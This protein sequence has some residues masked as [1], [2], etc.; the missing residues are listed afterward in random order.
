MHPRIAD[1]AKMQGQA[2]QLLRTAVEGLSDDQLRRK[3]SPS[4]NDMLWVAAHLTTVRYIMAGLLGLGLEKP[5][6]TRFDRGVE[7]DGPE[8]AI[9]EILARLDEVSAALAARYEQLG[10]GEL[11]APSGRFP[12]TDRTIGGAIHCLTSHDAYHL[13]QLGFLRRMVGASRVVG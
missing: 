13:G 11:G 2:A 4:N 10:D 5:W 7:P 1:Q 6:G 3:G 9:D 8:P 12:S